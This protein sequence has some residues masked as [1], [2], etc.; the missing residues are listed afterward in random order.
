MGLI[1][2]IVVIIIIGIIFDDK[3]GTTMA[4]GDNMK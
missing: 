4:A 2:F 3:M 1:G